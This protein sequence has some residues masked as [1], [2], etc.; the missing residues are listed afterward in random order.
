MSAVLSPRPYAGVDSFWHRL[1]GLSVPLLCEVEWERPEAATHS[2]PGHPGSVTVIHAWLG[3]IDLLACP[4]IGEALLPVIEQA[5]HQQAKQIDS[6]KANTCDCCD[7]QPWWG[8]KHINQCTR[9]GGV[10]F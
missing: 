5:F 9:C 8:G 4:L 7:M 1:E 3:T 2:E 10:T 6:A